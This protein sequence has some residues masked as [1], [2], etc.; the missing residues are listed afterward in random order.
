MRACVGGSMVRNAGGGEI[1]NSTKRECVREFMN[2]SLN[3]FSQRDSVSP[4]RY[5]SLGNCYTLL[6]VLR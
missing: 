2:G 4:E 6:L 5:W 3:E 1:K